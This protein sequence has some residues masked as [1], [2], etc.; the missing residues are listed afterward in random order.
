MIERLVIKDGILC[1]GISENRNSR[2]LNTEGLLDLAKSLSHSV[3]AV[4]FLNST[5]IID[6]FHLL[7][8]AQNAVNALNGDY[9]ISRSLDVEIVLYT[10]AQRQIGRALDILGVTD[11]MPIIGIICIDEDEKKVRNCLV[12]A[13][14]E[15]GEE[16]SPMFAPAPEKILSLMEIYGITELE[17]KQFTNEDDLTSRTQALS[18]CIVSRVSQVALGS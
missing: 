12:S 5:M 4:Q 9:M 10:S 2:G 3:L 18:K 8:G 11:Q 17:M 1:I 7:S 14:K 13:A 6:E 16:I 15:V